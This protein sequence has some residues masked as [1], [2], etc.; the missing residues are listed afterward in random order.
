MYR[1]PKI[2]SVSLVEQSSPEIVSYHEQKY[3]LF[4]SDRN[5]VSK[6]STL[7]FD[8]HNQKRPLLRTAAIHLLFALTITRSPKSIDAAGATSRCSVNEAQMNVTCED[9]IGV[10]LFQVP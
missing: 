8:R 4:L 9:E 7:A 5:A 6:I 2:L 1:V 3:G 10:N